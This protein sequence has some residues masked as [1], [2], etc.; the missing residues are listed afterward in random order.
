MPNNRPQSAAS[1][2]VE[3][4]ATTIDGREDPLPHAMGM[5]TNS[6]TFRGFD[7]TRLRADISGTEEYPTV[8]LIRGGGSRSLWRST[9]DVLIGAGYR[10]VNLD[11]CG[12][13]GGEW[14]DCRIC[15]HVDA[16]IFNLKEALALLDTR[17]AIVAAGVGA[18]IAACALEANSSNLAM[19]LVLADLFA[20]DATQGWHALREDIKGINESGPD[21]TPRLSD[22]SDV[23]DMSRRLAKVAPTIAIPVHLVQ[24]V[25]SEPTSG[26]GT[27]VLAK[28]L[29]NAEFTE[30]EGVDHLIGEQ[31]VEAFNA[32]LIDFLDRQFSR[33]PMQY[34]S[35]SDP[36][37]LRNALGCFA[38]GV[39]VISAFATNGRPIG[40]TANSFTSVSLDPP[41]VAVCIAH[42]SETGNLLKHASSFAI[43]VLQVGQQAISNQFAGKSDDR[44]ENAPWEKGE[45][46]VPIFPN[47]LCIFECAQH[48]IHEGG[49]HFIL[50][51]KVRKATYEPR[52]DPLLFFRGGYRRLRFA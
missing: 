38:T 4:E 5:I 2:A 25:F 24:G 14:S 36:R 21:W 45:F 30:I 3:G 32:L 44:F 26:D 19:G 16:L 40:L 20:K 51:G 46:G 31:R 48:A 29:I 34:R 52:H 43:N 6:R 49:D 11:L 9:T 22:C 28:L 50:V 7:G 13:G 37:S 47:S 33:T 8:L 17:P 10:V 39:T 23:S 12:H 35:G 41:L 15:D 42:E 1:V 27:N 18:C